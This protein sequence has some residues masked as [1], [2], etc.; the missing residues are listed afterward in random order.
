MK[1]DFLELKNVGGDYKGIEDALNAPQS[2]RGRK[3]AISV[4][5]LTDGAKHHI[6]SFLKEMRLFVVSDKLAARNAV[7]KLN[8][9]KKGCALYISERDDTLL[10]ARNITQTSMA[11]RITALSRMIDG[12]LDVAVITAEGLLQKYPNLELLRKLQTTLAVDDEIPPQNLADKLA[13]AGYTR[14]DTV[15]EQGEFALRGDIFDVYPTGRE[16]PVRINFFDDFVESIKQF[17]LATM[18]SNSDLDEITVAPASDILADE[19]SLQDLRKA[20]QVLST[21]AQSIFNELKERASVGACPSELVWLRPFLSS[22]QATI[23]D[24]LRNDTIIV[25]DEPKV[26]WEKLDLCQKEH[27]SRVASLLEVGEIA[28]QHSKAI[29]T[30]EN[31]LSRLEEFRLLSLSSLSMSNPMFKPT[32]V[33]SPNSRPVTK[34]YLDTTA[35]VADLRV[36]LMNGFKVVLCAR[37]PDA[38]KNI[39]NSLRENYV[40]VMLDGEPKF[41][42]ALLT[43]EGVETGFLYPEQKLL[44]VGANELVGKKYDAGRISQKST[45][46]DIKEGD[47]VVHSVHGVGICVGIT[48]M[49]VGEFEKEFVVLRYKNNDLLYVAIDQMD[50]LHKF[51]GE[52]NPPLNRLGGKDFLREKEKVKKSLRKLAI[53]L[54]Q[55]YAEREKI[56][57]HVYPADT[58]WQKQFEDAFEYEETA[59]QMTAINTIKD[60]M[61]HGKVIDRLVCGDVGFGK[62]EVAFRII[63]KTILESRQAV[64]LAPT[65]I[66]CKQHYELLSQRLSPFGIECRCLTRMQSTSENQETLQMLRDGTLLV[67][68]ATHRILSKDVDFEDLGLL[69]LDEEQRFGVE[70]K[71]RLKEKFPTINVL[72]LSAT[73]IPR[74]LNMSLSGVRDISLLETAPKGRLPIQTYVV[75]Y[76]EALIVDAIVREVSRGGQVLI[77]HNSIMQMQN[78]KRILQSKLPDAVKITYAHGQMPPQE[79]ENRMSEFYEKKFDVLIATTIIENGIDL[80]D[81]NTLIVIN[82]ENFG[83]SQLYQLRGRVGRR[84]V[85]AHAYF[86]VPRTSEMTP[87]AEKRLTALLDN[88]EIGSGFKISIADLSIRGS[89]TMLGAEQHGHI[90]RVGYEMYIELLNRTI[91][92]LKTGKTPSE[93]DM[94]FKIDASAY[95]RNDY[96]S[97]RDKLRIYKRI[98]AIRTV[99]DRELLIRELTDVYGDVDTPL[100]NLM[101]IALIKNMAKELDVKRIISGKN[102]VGVNF[103]SDA[104]FANRELLG[105]VAEHSKE[106]VLTQTI[107]PSLIFDSEAKTPQEKIEMLVKFFSDVVSK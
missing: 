46:I 90:E 103:H 13:K 87:T 48:Q 37:T 84:G 31:I 83:L 19:K 104:V 59:D 29:F 86:T 35:L 23:F 63:F 53:N 43:T 41:S 100:R 65:T 3:A 51:I 2:N 102:G 66:L 47:Y 76:S 38:V 11:E 6:T 39:R 64:L 79:L 40:P 68:V 58:E 69:V 7:E 34:Y 25:F 75:E 16:N 49:K 17:E 107:P 45:F 15:S 21:Q 72:T 91:E 4:S 78:F 30:T 61:Q 96:V 8:G 60:E 22:A 5:K 106:V 70:H 74:T 99:S 36:Y 81:A 62:T 82:A 55:L 27:K 71:E 12:R 28:P 32:A 24:Y 52:E 33:F 1:L 97:A 9:M 20:G 44:V 14:V 67:V 42:K 54:L 85:L 56:K 94:D 80:P 50:A 101:G 105:A 88:S 98:S 73:P 10:N 92:E 77:L 93:K 57:G 95:I 89:G 18:T 26:V